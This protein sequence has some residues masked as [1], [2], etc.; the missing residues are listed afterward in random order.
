MFLGTHADNMKDAGI[1]NRMSHGESHTFA[2]FTNA[3]VKSIRKR[4]AIAL[5]QINSIILRKTWKHVL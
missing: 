1:K 5:S 4:Y 2:K 3:D